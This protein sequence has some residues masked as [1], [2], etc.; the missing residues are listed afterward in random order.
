MVSH[1][2]KRGYVRQGLCND[3]GIYNT[4]CVHRL[5]ALMFIPNPTNLPQVDHIDG[6]KLNN[7]YL[8]LRW[9][10]NL[11]NA[12]AAI[13]LGLMP[14]AVFPGEEI[15]H[16]I[17]QMISQNISIAEISR[18][19]GYS[20]DAIMAIRLRRNWTHVSS[21][22]VF[23]EPHKQNYPSENTVREMCK[24]ILQ[25]MSTRT[26]MDS[27]GVRKETILRT[28]NGKIHKQIM[29]DMRQLF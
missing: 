12:H 9:V 15:V 7:Y 20:Y 13:S 21:Q 24:M 14:H 26:I 28:K 16:Q 4:L 8:N 10:S 3:D 22:Y 25:N 5:V 19:T 11:E 27:L 1:L 23:P 18:K 2:D 29:N 17:C 6:N